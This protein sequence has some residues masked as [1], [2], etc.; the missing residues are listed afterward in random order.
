MKMVEDTDT[1]RIDDVHGMASC[2][3]YWDLDLIRL[4]T[5]ADADEDE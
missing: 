1:E 4:D 3:E 5:D 2:G